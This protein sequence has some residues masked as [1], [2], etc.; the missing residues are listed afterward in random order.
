MLADVSYVRA[1]VNASFGMGLNQAHDFTITP[2]IYQEVAAPAFESHTTT[3]FTYTLGL[4]VQ[5]ILNKHWQIGTGYQF[6]AWGASNLARASGQT[7]NNGL[8]LSNL[9]I[10]SL[11]LSLSYI[12]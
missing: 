7:L 9:Y 3:A 1:Y 10:N 6:A 12:S 8:S 2:K 11:Q 5:R 4:G